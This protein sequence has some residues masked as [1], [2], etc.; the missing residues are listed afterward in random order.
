MFWNRTCSCHSNSLGTSPGSSTEECSLCPTLTPRVPCRRHG[1]ANWAYQ[2]PSAPAGH[3]QPAPSAPACSTL[4]TSTQTPTACV[5]HMLPVLRG[6]QSVVSHS[7][8]V[9]QPHQCSHTHQVPQAPGARGLDQQ[10]GQLAAHAEP[11][12]CQPCLT[13]PG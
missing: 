9:R 4:T 7:Q 3:H 6:Q 2:T 10:Y 1:S 5:L 8:P 13:G 11:V 12:R